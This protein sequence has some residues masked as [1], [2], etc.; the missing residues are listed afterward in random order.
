MKG[1]IE[2]DID[3]AY[4][5]CASGI[6]SSITTK[7]M[8]PAANAKAYGKIGSAITTATAPNKPAIG[9]TIPLNWPYLKRND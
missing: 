2:H 4:A 9:S 8:A 7:I 1:L 3:I 6:M 5:V